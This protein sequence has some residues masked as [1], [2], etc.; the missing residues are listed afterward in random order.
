MNINSKFQMIRYLLLIL[1]LNASCAQKKPSK[2]KTNV[3]EISNKNIDL[4]GDITN[5][6]LKYTSEIQSIFQ[7][8]KGNY[9]FGSHHEGVAKFDGDEFTYFTINDGL[10]GN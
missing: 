10:S 6:K 4:L 8:S 1:V 3:L 5:T 2:T 7:D 9:W